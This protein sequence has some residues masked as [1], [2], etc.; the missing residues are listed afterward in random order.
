MCL[1]RRPGHGTVDVVVVD[2]FGAMSSYNKVVFCSKLFFHPGCSASVYST[3]S[4]SGTLDT[5]LRPGGGD[6]EVGSKHTC[7]MGGM[8]GDTIRLTFLIP[9]LRPSRGHAI[10]KI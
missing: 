10:E 7:A 6:G 5:S 8:R 1:R 2:D 4:L 9:S 3:P